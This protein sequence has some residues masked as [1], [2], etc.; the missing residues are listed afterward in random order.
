MNKNKLMLSLSVFVAGLIILFPINKNIIAL[1]IERD[2]PTLDDMNNLSREQIANLLINISGYEHENLT[3]EYVLDYFD[4][5]AGVSLLERITEY[6]EDHNADIINMSSS[7]L[8]ME[9]EQILVESM[10]YMNN[11]T[12]VYKPL[13]ITLYDI[14][15]ESNLTFYDEGPVWNSSMS[16]PQASSNNLFGW[17]CF[18]LWL[19][20]LAAIINA[21]IAFIEFDFDFA[22]EMQQLTDMLMTLSQLLGCD[23]LANLTPNAVSGASPAY[24]PDPCPCGS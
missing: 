20:S 22:D 6:N 8:Y 24:D 16:N 17:L 9:Q 3:A 21:I 13:G 18:G 10:S 15:D 4:K 1:E 12:G 2:I 19:L 7:E 11:M 23:D 5:D 14:Y